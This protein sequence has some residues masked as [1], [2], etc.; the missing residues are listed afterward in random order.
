MVVK[1]MGT[2]GHHYRTSAACTVSEGIPL[3]FSAQGLEQ[4]FLLH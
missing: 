2:S 4:L 1:R 3:S